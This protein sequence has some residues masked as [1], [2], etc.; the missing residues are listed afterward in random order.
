MRECV[1]LQVATILREYKI[2]HAEVIL[3]ED[4][5]ED[6]FLDVLE[7]FFF[8]RMITIMLIIIIFILVIAIIVMMP[9]GYSFHYFCYYSITH[10]HTHTHLQGTECTSRVFTYSTRLTAYPD[11]QKTNLK[12]T[13]STRL[14]ACPDR[15]QIFFEKYKKISV[16]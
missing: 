9:P 8:L 6:D 2:Q 13:L 1:L 16:Q 15:H 12:N 4:C 5:T 11:R 10:T 3:K 14:T 7:G